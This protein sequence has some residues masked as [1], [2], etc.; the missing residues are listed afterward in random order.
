MGKARVKKTQTRQNKPH[1][2][3]TEEQ[4]GVI[5]FVASILS[6]DINLFRIAAIGGGRIV[7]G[8]S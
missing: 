4:V 1:N 6:I 2:C 5:E 8:L 7:R 3:A